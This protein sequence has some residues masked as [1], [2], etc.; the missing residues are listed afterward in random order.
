MK[1]VIAFLT[2][3]LMLGACYVGVSASGYTP[4]YGT[5]D[6]TIPQ[7]LLDDLDDCLDFLKSCCE[8][9]STFPIPAGYTLDDMEVAGIYPLYEVSG[10]GLTGTFEEMVQ[11]GTKT[12]MVD[13]TIG[14]TPYVTMYVSK[15]ADGSYAWGAHE[16]N[17]NLFALSEADIIADGNIPTNRIVDSINFFREAYTPQGERILYPITQRAVWFLDEAEAAPVNFAT[18]QYTKQVVDAYSAVRYQEL[19]AEY[20]D[21]AFGGGGIWSI[22]EVPDEFIAGLGL[23]EPGRY[24]PPQ[25]TVVQDDPAPV[26][27]GTQTAENSGTVGNSV[28][29]IGAVFAV[30]GCAIIGFWIYQKKKY[31]A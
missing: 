23:K 9:S 8:G 20:G 27:T 13:I 17:S 18:Y 16:T 15:Q 5:Y 19:L 22:G 4:T 11:S 25:Q 28:W 12:Y 2:A 30:A 31:A 26:T 21:T 1:R 3:V 10:A 29:I 14:G 6:E 7:R 24:E